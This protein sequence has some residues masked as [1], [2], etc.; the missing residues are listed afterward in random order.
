MILDKS[1]PG[2]TDLAQ[3]GLHC[4]S[5]GNARAPS[6]PLPPTQS[7]HG[8]SLHTSA[9]VIVP[10]HDHFANNMVVSVFV[11]QPCEHPSSELV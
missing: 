11:L 8:I 3:V 2:C 7:A 4:R 10:Y 9:G 5:S 1:A 6:T